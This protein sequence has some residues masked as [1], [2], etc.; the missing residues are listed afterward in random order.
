[1]NLLKVGVLAS[2]HSP[3]QNSG[4]HSEQLFSESISESW[5]FLVCGYIKLDH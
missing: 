1:M 2:Q 5:G 3:G 4:I